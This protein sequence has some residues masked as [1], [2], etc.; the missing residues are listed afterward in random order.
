MLKGIDK[1]LDMIKIKQAELE[2]GINQ[3]E[4]M[5]QASIASDRSSGKVSDSNCSSFKLACLCT[6][7]LV[8]SLVIMG[9]LVIT[10]GIKHS[11]KEVVGEW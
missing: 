8:G 5:G 9:G 10:I 6:F 4:M 2:N 11:E 1:D 3:T 7:L